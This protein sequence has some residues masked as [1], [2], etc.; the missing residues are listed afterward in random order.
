MKVAAD[1]VV[2]LGSSHGPG[3]GLVA[4]QLA[5]ERIGVEQGLVV[6]D[7][8]IDADHVVL[9]QGIVVE[10]GAALVHG[11]V[12]REV[13]VVVQIRS[14]GDDPVHESRL[15]QRNQAAHAQTGGGQ[16]SRDR[17]ADRAIR[18][19]KPASEDLADLTQPPRV[20]AY[21]RVVDQVR[22]DLTS[23]DSRRRDPSM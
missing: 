8:V 2:K 3:E 16:G 15:D 13:S 19:E 4:N 12:E 22:G 7:H 9:P 17:Q 5:V 21:K 23:V 20:V 14:G 1:L 10:V 11:Q 18:L 6:E